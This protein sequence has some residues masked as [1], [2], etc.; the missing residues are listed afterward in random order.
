MNVFSA[1]GLPRLTS[2]TH[3]LALYPGQSGWAIARKYV[4]SITHSLVLLYSVSL[5]SPKGYCHCYCSAASPWLRVVP[6][7]LRQSLCWVKDRYGNPPVYILENGFSDSTGRID[8]QDR[9][10]YLRRYINEVLKGDDLLMVCN[11]TILQAFFVH[12]FAI[13]DMIIMCNYCPC[14]YE[15]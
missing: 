14:C 9:I 11:F 2:T 13:E 3:L 1:Y 4:H 15:I 7:G 12:K 6:W 8:D 5:I 10:D